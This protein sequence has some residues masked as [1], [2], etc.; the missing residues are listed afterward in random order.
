MFFVMGANIAEK[1]FHEKGARGWSI[2]CGWMSLGR[3]P[4]ATL[5]KYRTGS[6]S[7]RTNVR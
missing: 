2:G 7:D 1:R 6:G 3:I 4:E 5:H